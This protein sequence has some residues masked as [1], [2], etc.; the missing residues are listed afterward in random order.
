MK[1]LRQ[2]LKPM[3]HTYRY[4][5][6]TQQWRIKC[7]PLIAIVYMYMHNSVRSSGNYELYFVIIS[8]GKFGEE[9]AASRTE[10]FHYEGMYH[11]IHVHILYMYLDTCTLCIHTTFSVCTFRNVYVHII[12]LMKR[13]LGHYWCTF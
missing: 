6:T 1:K 3:T 13:G 12:H 10:Q 4:I 7:A 8:A 11:N 2:P 9:V 5:Y